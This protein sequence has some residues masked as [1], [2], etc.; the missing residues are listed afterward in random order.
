MKRAPPPVLPCWLWRSSRNG[1]KLAEKGVKQIKVNILSRSTLRKIIVMKRWG[2]YSC[3]SSGGYHQCWIRA[4]WW[5]RSQGGCWWTYKYDKKEKDLICPQESSFVWANCNVVLSDFAPSE[6]QHVTKILWYWKRRCWWKWEEKVKV[7]PVH[8]LAVAGGNPGDKKSSSCPDCNGAR[9]SLSSY[10]YHGQ[11][12]HG[13]ERT[14]NV[15]LLW[16]QCLAGS[17]LNTHLRTHTG[18]NHFKCQHCEKS[19]RRSGLFSKCFTGEDY[20]KIHMKTH[21]PVPRLLPSFDS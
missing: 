13:S 16:Q 18:E 17:Q 2:W 6:H 7:T 4:T 21:V 3:F 11:I 8:S 12:L 15:W 14:L 19:F 20:V 9:D 5:W 10:K 1:L